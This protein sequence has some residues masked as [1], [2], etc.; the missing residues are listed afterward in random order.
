MAETDDQGARGLAGSGAVFPWPL[1]L[2]GM[3]V[4]SAVFSL[5]LQPTEE[6]GWGGRLFRGWIDPSFRLVVIPVIGLV[7][8]IPVMVALNLIY[9]WSRRPSR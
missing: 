7:L 9:A 2:F 1:Y 5:I 3:I 8:G 4:T 6:S